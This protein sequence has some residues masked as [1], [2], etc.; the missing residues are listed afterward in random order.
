MHDIFFCP[1]Q[2]FAYLTFPDGITIDTLCLFSL[3]TTKKRWYGGPTS[4]DVA[5]FA[6]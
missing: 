5:A 2:G 4:Q 1:G 3:A 6:Y